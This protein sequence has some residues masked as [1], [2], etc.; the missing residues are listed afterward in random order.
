MTA[1]NTIV[2]SQ[3]QAFKN[4]VDSRN[5]KNPN[6]EENIV[7]VLQGY[8]KGVDRIVFNGDG[9]SREWEDEAR[10]RGLSNNKTTPLALKSMISEKAKKIFGELKV[11]AARDRE[12]A[13]ELQ[14]AMLATQDKSYRP[15]RNKAQEAA[16]KA[17]RVRNQLAGA[18]HALV[19]IERSLVER[20]RLLRQLPGGLKLLVTSSEP[21]AELRELRVD[22]DVAGDLAQ[23]V[24]AIAQTVAMD[25]SLPRYVKMRTQHAAER[26]REEAAA[27]TGRYEAA[28]D[29]LSGRETVDAI[30]GEIE[31]LVTSALAAH[32]KLAKV[33]Q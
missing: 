21:K 28:L 10:A 11:A 3:L 33:L 8:M 15:R 26:A 19:E 4:E 31:A 16:E 32:P 12:V 22:A 25:T 24:Y 20:Q 9:Y 17:D 7:A 2:A 23:R 6:T 5:E 27:A 14:I 13:A 1:L 18:H 30:S 29:R